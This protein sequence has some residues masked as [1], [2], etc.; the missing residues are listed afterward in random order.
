[1]MPKRHTRLNLPRSF[2][3]PKGNDSPRQD[4]NLS[5]T[6]LRL[7][8]I[9]SRLL[10]KE[11]SNGQVKPQVR[12]HRIT[13]GI[14]PLLERK[15][16]MMEKDQGPRKSFDKQAEL[17]K[18]LKMIIKKGSKSEYGLPQTDATC[19]VA[20]LPY[21]ARKI[22]KNE[23]RNEF[24]KELKRN[25]E[26]TPLS[27]VTVRWTIR[28]DMPDVLYRWFILQELCKYG[29]I[30]SVIFSGHRCAQVVF[31]DILSA[32][33]AMNTHSVRLPEQ[34]YHCFWYYPFMM[35]NYRFKCTRET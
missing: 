3:I 23:C 21:L 24:R 25:N 31:S 18:K 28:K 32:C 34:L 33:K 1:M 8:R 2:P 16:N 13:L 26:C 27:T 20:Q 35:K 5:A 29:P 9:P 4:Q 22:S 30:D 7:S 14:S 17:K 12:P 15:D 11:P 6:F 10:H 19:Q